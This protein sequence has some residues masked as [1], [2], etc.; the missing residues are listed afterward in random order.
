[1]KFS[2]Q[3]AMIFS[4]SDSCEN[5]AHRTSPNH[6]LVVK[7]HISGTAGLAPDWPLMGFRNQQTPLGAHLV[8]DVYR[9]AWVETTNVDPSPSMKF[10]FFKTMFHYLFHK[11]E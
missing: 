1:M 8:G 10:F 7:L 11:L 5:I 3:D 4:T 2:L 9:C 6:R